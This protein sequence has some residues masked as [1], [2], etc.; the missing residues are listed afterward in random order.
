MTNE[1]SVQ[2]SHDFVSVTIR[3][4]HRWRNTARLL[5]VIEA[6]VLPLGGCV[7][8]ITTQ[9][10]INSPLDRSTDGDVLREEQESLF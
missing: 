4:P 1:T 3:I 7:T 9:P 6:Y 8:T 2:P 10:D 5:Q